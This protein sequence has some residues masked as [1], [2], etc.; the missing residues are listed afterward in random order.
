MKYWGALEYCSIGVDWG[1][2]WRGGGGGGGGGSFETVLEAT[3]VVLRRTSVTPPSIQSEM[4]GCILD[5][6]HRYSSLG[7]QCSN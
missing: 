4:Q 3:L 6:V 2:A 1:A 7:L 5:H